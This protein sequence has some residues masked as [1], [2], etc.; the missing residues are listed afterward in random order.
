MEK[1]ELQNK[2]LL[3]EKEELQASCAG[4]QKQN[5]DLQEELKNT[6]VHKK[7]NT[8]SQNKAVSLK[9]EEGLSQVLFHCML[10]GENLGGFSPYYL[11]N[12]LPNHTT[13]LLQ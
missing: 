11:F 7:V 2:N 10:P 9:D 13:P 6:Q 3:K 12:P 1:I 5:S 8:R 4:L